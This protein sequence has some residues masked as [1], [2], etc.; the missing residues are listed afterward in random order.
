MFYRFLLSMNVEQIY[1]R[2]IKLQGDK[3]ASH[4]TFSIDET[5]N[6]N[7]RRRLLGLTYLIETFNVLN[8]H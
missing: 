8:N 4:I 7:N 3:R 1:L 6:D 2:F 5:K